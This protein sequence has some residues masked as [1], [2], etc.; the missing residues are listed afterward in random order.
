[1][2]RCEIFMKKNGFKIVPVSTVNALTVY[3]SPVVILNRN[4]CTAELAEALWRCLELPASVVKK[5]VTGLLDFRTHIQDLLDQLQEKSLDNLYS[6]SVSCSIEL[7]GRYI[8]LKHHRWIPRYGR[9]TVLEEVVKSVK[10]GKQFLA[11]K[12]LTC[13][14]SADP[15]VRN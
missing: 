13:L 15:E 11:E 10:A 3:R 4:C 12:V 6:K 5:E 2:K 14:S 7:T 8:R 1:M 9:V